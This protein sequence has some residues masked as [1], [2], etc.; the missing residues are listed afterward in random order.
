[1]RETRASER[2]L[3]C[4]FGT[5]GQDSP[6]VKNKDVSKTEP[7]ELAS[8]KTYLIFLNFYYFVAV[9]NFIHFFSFSVR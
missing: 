1:M 4:V 3:Y 5:R 6:K 9:N 2:V 8:V 7:V